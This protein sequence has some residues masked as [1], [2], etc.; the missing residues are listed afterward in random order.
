MNAS[1]VHFLDLCLMRS[2]QLGRDQSE[3]VSKD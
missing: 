3:L 2:I 1:S